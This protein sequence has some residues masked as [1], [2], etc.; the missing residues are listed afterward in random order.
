M[1][2][3]RY[4]AFFSLC[5]VFLT[6]RL[7]SAQEPIRVSTVAHPD[8]SHTETQTDPSAGTVIT[9]TYAAGGELK[10]RGVYKAGPDGRVNEGTFYDG[11]GK[12]LRRALYARDPMGNVIE[13]AYYDQAGNIVRRKQYVYGSDGRVSGIK[14][15]GSDGRL[16]NSATRPVMPVTASV[17][18]GAGPRQGT[19]SE[20]ASA[21]SENATV[22]SPQ[23][24]PASTAPTIPTAPSKKKKKSSGPGRP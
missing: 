23:S 6:A 10:E 2:T 21:P 22:V 8:G 24:E 19:P 13:E 4:P 17:G 15:Y 16:T 5:V 20:A 12:F 14:E 7:V 18:S 3:L 11:K 1:H 9:S